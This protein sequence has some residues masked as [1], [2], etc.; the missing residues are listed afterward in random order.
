MDPEEVDERKG[1]VGILSEHGPVK[2]V[3]ELQV[4][5]CVEGSLSD[6]PGWVRSE[7]LASALLSVKSGR[8]TKKSF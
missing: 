3:M 1:N 7:E 4:N 6:S 5:S 2:I 8:I